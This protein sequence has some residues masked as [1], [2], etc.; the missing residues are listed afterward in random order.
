MVT[1]NLIP[2]AYAGGFCFTFFANFAEKIGYEED[3]C[4]RAC[5]VE[6]CLSGGSG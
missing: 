4:C 2:L 3:V 1:D 5:A 6:L